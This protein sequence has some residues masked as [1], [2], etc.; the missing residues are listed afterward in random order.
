MTIHCDQRQKSVSRASLHFRWREK[1]GEQRVGQVLK[2]G[3]VG[4][5]SCI[6][7]NRISNCWAFLH[8]TMS[9]G[10]MKPDAIGRELVTML[11][12]IHRA[13]KWLSTLE[14]QIGYRWR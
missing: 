2:Q 11:A 12:L 4:N 13:G 1:A 8:V 10:G 14:V 6:Y 5:S 7:R 9:L 3:L